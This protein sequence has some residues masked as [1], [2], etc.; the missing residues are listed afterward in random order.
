M[1]LS[2]DLQNDWDELKESMDAG[3][4]I[5][6]ILLLSRI[7]GEFAAMAGVLVAALK[8]ATILS[9]GLAALGVPF[10]ASTI[11][12]LLTQAWP[13]ILIAYDKMNREERQDLREALVFL[14]LSPKLF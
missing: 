11:Q 8:V 1:S 13:K 12:N 2:E 4:V 5:K 9:G 6:G 10:A 14:N 7:A 3:R